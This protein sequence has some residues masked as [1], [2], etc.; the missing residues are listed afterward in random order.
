MEEEEEEDEE[1]EE[2]ENN[3]YAKSYFLMKHQPHIGTLGTY[4][5]RIW[6][7]S[8]R[9]RLPRHYNILRN[10]KHTRGQSVVIAG[11]TING[12][13]YFNMIKLTHTDSQ[14]HSVATKGKLR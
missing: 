14:R 7:S 2:E 8:L 6:E 12:I 13:A 9:Q 1:E 10:H 4:N 11:D 3:Y 5:S